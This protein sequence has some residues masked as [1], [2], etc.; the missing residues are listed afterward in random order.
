VKPL[1]PFR[2]EGVRLTLEEDARARTF[3]EAHHYSK[4]FPFALLNVAAWR[5]G[6]MIGC[7]VFGT[8]PHVHGYKRYGLPDSTVELN[9]LAIIP[10]Q[11]T[12]GASWLISK[13]LAILARERPDITDV[14]SYCDPAP[15]FSAIGVE[16]KR[17][18]TGAIYKAANAREVGRAHPRTILLCP[19]GTMVTTRTMTDWIVK[20]KPAARNRLLAQSAPPPRD[21]ETRAEWVARCLVE[22]PWRKIWNP[23]NVAYAWHLRDRPEIRE[24]VQTSF[25]F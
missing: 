25:A 10:G 17:A 6:E 20:G 16:V 22:A 8:S 2:P 3:I 7:V 23:G 21:G 19:N 15:R 14:L 9:R 5:N 11:G 4:T 1:H 13:S 18:H 24:P 12:G